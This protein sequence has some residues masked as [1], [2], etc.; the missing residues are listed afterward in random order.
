ML[1][2]KDKVGIFIG[3]VTLDGIRRASLRRCPLTRAEEEVEA[4]PRKTEDQPPRENQGRGGRQREAYRSGVSGF[5]SFEGLGSG[6]RRLVE[7]GAEAES[8][9]GTALQPWW[10]E[11]GVAR[12]CPDM[13]MKP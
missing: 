13:W 4:S 5:G 1:S 3:P 6:P 10:G 7:K 9:S 12:R 8:R 2:R 11:C